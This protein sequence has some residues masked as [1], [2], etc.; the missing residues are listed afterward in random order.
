MSRRSKG[1]TL[2]ELLVV[3]GIIALLISILLP[4][5]ARARQAAGS[6][7][8][9]SNL[10]QL[11]M[12]FQMYANDNKFTY[13]LARGGGGP[14]EWLNF[15]SS[16]NTANRQLEDSAIAPYMGGTINDR[17]LQCPNDPLNFVWP[18]YRWSYAMNTLME[19][20]KLSKIVDPSDKLLLIHDTFRNDSRYWHWV[21]GQYFDR[22]SYEDD[23]TI[24]QADDMA[25]THFS[26]VKG[27][28]NA[29][30]ADGH[31]ERVPRSWSNMDEKNKAFPTQNNM[32][33]VWND[34]SPWPTTFIRSR[35]GN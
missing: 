16:W 28:G 13:P 22:I 18:H 26:Q 6:A 2:V 25:V 33:T 32:G 9:L 11:G 35:D 23:T 27:S 8:C 10:R 15:P 24:S 3:I 14:S 1:F 5:L 29:L 17:A 21:T 7:V 19:G 20:I 31:A 34:Q 30:F 12:A 4:S